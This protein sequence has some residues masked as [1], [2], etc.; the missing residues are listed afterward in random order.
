[1]SLWSRFKLLFSCTDDCSETELSF[2]SISDFG[3]NSE[4][5]PNPAHIETA[6]R[7][8]GR[9]VR[10]VDDRGYQRE[11]FAAAVNEQSGAVAFFESRAKQLRRMVDVTIS[12]HI[13]GIDGRHV[14]WEIVT[15]NPYFGC[16]VGFMKWF[17]DSILVIYR[18]KHN[19]YVCRFG[20][21]FPA[22]CKEIGDYWIVNGS[23]L[24]SCC[25]KNATVVQRLSLPKLSKLPNISKEE[26]QRE[27]VFPVS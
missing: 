6:T 3:S 12:L 4:S 2:G 27:G 11:I 17:S 10:F 18:E 23:V 26:A 21:D 15:Y 24:A 5:E 7:L 25:D 1:M 16:E 13:Q 8:L 9:S 19:T 22:L 14:Q 20:L